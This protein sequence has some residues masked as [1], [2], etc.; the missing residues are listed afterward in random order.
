MSDIDN[1]K[2]ETQL[3][4]ASYNLKPEISCRRQKIASDELKTKN[5]FY[6]LAFFTPGINP[7]E[8][9]S[10]NTIRLTPNCRM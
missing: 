2:K 4:H 7:F 6:Q 10:R 3:T 8:A 5:G 1:M 9:I